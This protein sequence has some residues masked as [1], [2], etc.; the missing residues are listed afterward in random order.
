MHS[1]L[2]NEIFNFFVVKD[3]KKMPKINNDFSFR[4]VLLKYNRFVIYI[5]Y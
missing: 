2:K 5:N 1:F 4:K 3:K